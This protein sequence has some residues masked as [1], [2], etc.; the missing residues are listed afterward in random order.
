MTI[1]DLA[2]LTMKYGL[3]CQK[4]VKGVMSSPRAHA[5]IIFPLISRLFS[6]SAAGQAITTYIRNHLQRCEVQQ[7]HPLLLRHVLSGTASDDELVSAL[8]SRVGGAHCMLNSSEN[9]VTNFRRGTMVWYLSK[10]AGA[11]CPFTRAGIRLSDYGENGKIGCTQNS[12]KERKRERDR[13]RR[14]QQCGQKRK[15]LFRACAD[16]GS[17]TD[18]MDEE[19]K[20]PPKV[21]ITL[22]LKPCNASAS[23]SSGSAGSTC[24]FNSQFHEIID[25]SRDSD[26]DSD[27]DDM[28]EEESQPSSPVDDDEQQLQH[29]VI[30]SSL[31]N[32]STSMPS[33][34]SS[35]E[36]IHTQHHNAYSEYARSLSVPFSVES[37]SPPPDSEEEDED[38][39]HTMIG[40]RH[41]GPMRSRS[42]FED[43]ED[44]DDEMDWDDDFFGDNDA[45]TETQWESPGPRSPSVQ[46]EDEVVVKQE[47]NDV[48]GLLA[49]W[50]DLESMKVINAVEHAVA[51]QHHLASLKMKQEEQEGTIPSWDDV[52]N[53]SMDGS[54]FKPEDE[55]VDLHPHETSIESLFRSDRRSPPPEIESPITPDS[56]FSPTG[57]ALEE[58]A[59][60]YAEALRRS[61][62]CW[63]TVELPGLDSLKPHELDESVWTVRRDARKDR[64]RA[65][66][67]PRDQADAS[68]SLPPSTGSAAS[69]ASGLG[70]TRVPMP[71]RL[72]LASQAVPATGAN[73]SASPQQGLSSP[74][75]LASLT[76]LSIHTPTSPDAPRVLS[77][78][79]TDEPVP[80]AGPSPSIK[81]VDSHLEP[82]A[83]DVVYSLEPCHPDIYVSQVDGKLPPSA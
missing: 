30:V 53:N 23:S 78:S 39:H 25:L 56:P 12:G 55:N 4:C 15:R 27:D 77:D 10:V 75:I 14:A 60:S 40:M 7:D 17:D 51:G 62:F 65:F 24:D 8:Y 31:P 9:R 76:S 1:K 19:E 37:A 63:N 73:W 16:K 29:H 2:E 41:Y 82:V 48:P 28:S 74:S 42:P 36:G 18:S 38:F 35:E 50:D 59:K 67:K 52:G 49:H 61:N 69:L 54:I 21:K 83:E 11:P 20:R 72:D 80:L 81:P 32:R 70:L 57:L 5:K 66:D 22:K 71:P 6:V 26:S 46:F 13:L 3:S 47:P 68:A 34:V 44:E 33:Y 79:L 58:Y 45:D 64:R 43:D